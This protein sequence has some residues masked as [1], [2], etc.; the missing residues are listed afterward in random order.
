MRLLFKGSLLEGR[1]KANPKRTHFE[2]ASMGHR[3]QRPKAQSRL[4]GLLVRFKVAGTNSDCTYKAS[5]TEPRQVPLVL[6]GS[7]PQTRRACDVCVTCLGLGSKS[8]DLMR[9][10]SEAVGSVPRSHQRQ[11]S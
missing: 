1:A 8:K 7:D 9:T 3:T 11:C 5:D 2:N 10:S 6:L 4:P